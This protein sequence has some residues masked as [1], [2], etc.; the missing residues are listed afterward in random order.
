MLASDLTGD[1]RYVPV[2]ALTKDEVSAL[3]VRVSAA[4]KAVAQV[5]ARLTAKR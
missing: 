4:S 1:A 5:L 3:S 2:D